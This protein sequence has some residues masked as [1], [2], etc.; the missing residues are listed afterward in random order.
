MNDTELLF[1][2]AGIGICVKKGNDFWG[3]GK[4]KKPFNRQGK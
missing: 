4:R 3:K 2:L 1:H